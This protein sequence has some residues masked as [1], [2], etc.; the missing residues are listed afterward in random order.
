MIGESFPTQARIPELFGKHLACEA[1][2][3]CVLG[4]Q[5]FR[6]LQGNGS[7]HVRELIARTGIDEGNLSCDA[8]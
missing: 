5:D 1:L 8:G 4:P 3:F 7:P 2:V 6:P